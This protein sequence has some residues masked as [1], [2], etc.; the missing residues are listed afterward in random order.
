MDNKI[1]VFDKEN[2]IQI[3]DLILDDAEQYSEFWEDVKIKYPGYIAML[4]YHN[5]QAPDNFLSLI[6]AEL[7]DDCISARL[8]HKRKL[9]QMPEGI[10][11]LSKED[12]PAFSMIHDCKNP[13]MYWTSTRIYEN[14]D[15]WAIFISD[16][17]YSLMNL[18][19]NEAEIFVVEADD[20]NI[21]TNLITA[22]VVDA[23]HHKMDSLLFMVD[24][25]DDA[26]IKIVKNLGFF[27]DGFYKGY[28]VK[29]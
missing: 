11:K 22:C 5:L 20:D 13:D 9:L 2:H 25:I 17:S 27:I 16:G 3:N 15:K 24:R 18:W 7:M 12:F 21:R 23:F 28:K 6:K 10:I 1:I 8:K 14:F 4:C 29:V 19:G 26:T